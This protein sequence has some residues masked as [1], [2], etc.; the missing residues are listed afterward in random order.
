MA[1]IYLAGGCFWGTEAYLSAIRGVTYTEVGYANGKT[2]NPSYEDVCH[3]NTGHAETVRVEYDPDVISL[4]FLLELFYDSID[5]TSRN[6]QGADIGT[7]YRT[8]IYYTN[9]DDLAVIERSIARLQAKYDVKIAIEVKPLENY[10]KAE[11]YHQKY[12]EKNPNGYCHIRK[13]R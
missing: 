11:E 12:L 13:Q 6:R 4:E 9:S 5:P 2:K 8:G 3:R 7:Q 1:E 10:Y